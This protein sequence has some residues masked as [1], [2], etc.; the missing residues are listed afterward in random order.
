MHSIDMAKL[1]NDGTRQESDRLN[2]I[3]EWIQSN[4]NKT[5]K[6]QSK[7]HSEQQSCFQV[8]LFRNRLSL[9]FGVRNGFNIY[10]YKSLY[11]N[12][13]YDV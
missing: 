13:F 11:L 9:L 10:V 12:V 1:Y 2:N 6:Q 7:I 4:Q 8:T 3:E 5:T